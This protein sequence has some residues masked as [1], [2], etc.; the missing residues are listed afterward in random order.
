MNA[1][2]SNATLVDADL[3]TDCRH[4]GKRLTLGDC[5]IVA[6]RQTT[7][8]CPSC[9]MILVRLAPA[10]RLG[11][12][13]ERGYL[14]GDFEVRTTAEIECVGAL[15]PVTEPQKAAEPPL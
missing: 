15:L 14:L 6:G 1:V 11:S 9:A 8:A 7:Y 4:C 12:I 2:L 13:D 10:P 3:K 5:R